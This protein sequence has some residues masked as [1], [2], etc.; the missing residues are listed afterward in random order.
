[1]SIFI[2]N[3]SV[4]KLPV[5]FFKR[6]FSENYHLV[7]F[8]RTC[9]M[10]ISALSRTFYTNRRISNHPCNFTAVNVQNIMR[11]YIKYFSLCSK[12]CAKKSKANVDKKRKDKI[13]DDLLDELSDDESETNNED[14]DPSGNARATTPAA[15]FIE[16]GQNKGQKKGKSFKT[17]LF[18]R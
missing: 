5:L 13:I 15:M 6:N 18:A 8:S 4:N 2:R 14:K 16:G 1:M 11:S 10:D 7:R 17:L 12:A 3:N 9:Q